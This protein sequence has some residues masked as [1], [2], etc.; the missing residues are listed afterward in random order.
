MISI[1]NWNSAIET[2]LSGYDLINTP[3]LNKGMA[4][5]DEERD[6]FHLHGLLPPHVGS[7]D[8]QVARRLKVRRAFATERPSL[9]I[10]RRAVNH[11]FSVAR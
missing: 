10:G 8:E 7:L 4:F 6:L 11:R 2:D 1:P 5:K 9:R 3:M